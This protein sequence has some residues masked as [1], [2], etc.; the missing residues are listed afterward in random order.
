MAIVLPFKG[1][2]P[3]KEFVSKFACPPYDVMDRDEAKEM[4]KGNEYSFLHVTRAEVDMDDSV[5]IHDESV[6]V[7]A[8]TNLEN[9]INNGVIFQDKAPK[10]Y[11]YRQIWKGHSQTGLVACTS[12][13]EYEKGIIRKHEF[14]RKDKEEDRTKP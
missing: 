3:K 11:I 9:F 6:Y 2:R 12:C 10:F 14:T 13:E 7:K 4:V 5:D 8:R 1:L